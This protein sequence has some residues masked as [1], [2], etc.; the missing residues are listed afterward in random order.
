[1]LLLMQRN[2]VIELLEQ[3]LRVIE[4]G[5]YAIWVFV[6]NCMFIREFCQ[7]IVKV[8]TVEQLLDR[9]SSQTCHVF[10]EVRLFKIL[11]LL[12]YILLIEVVLCRW[13]E[14]RNQLFVC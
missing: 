14:G 4:N 7:L 6:C 5:V 3:K 12:A 8:I 11:P 9:I 13:Y 1:M 2:L 10:F